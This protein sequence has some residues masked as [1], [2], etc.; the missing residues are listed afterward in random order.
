MTAVAVET[1]QQNAMYIPSYDIKLNPYYPQPQKPQSL[2]DHFPE[3]AFDGAREAYA[4]YRDAGSPELDDVQYMWT[5]HTLSRFKAEAVVTFINKE[6][7]I[8]R[9]QLTPAHRDTLP[10]GVLRLV[11]HTEMRVYGMIPPQ[12]A[13]LL[14]IYYS[15][16]DVVNF[17]GLCGYWKYNHHTRK[18]ELAQIYDEP[19]DSKYRYSE[20]TANWKTVQDPTFV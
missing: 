14:S 6:G 7:A 19:Y 13:K 17:K 8:A 15:V 3:H 5:P 9:M 10:R 20:S 12:I 18:W 2:P 1:N 4:A 11:P 16:P